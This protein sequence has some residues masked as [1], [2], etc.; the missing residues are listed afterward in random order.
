MYPS[1]WQINLK[2]F[3][4]FEVIL[5][6]FDEFMRFFFFGPAHRHLYSSNMNNE[7]EDLGNILQ[8]NYSVSSSSVP[9]VDFPFQFNF[10]SIYGSSL[11]IYFDNWKPSF[12]VPGVPTS[13]EKKNRHFDDFSSKIFFLPKLVGTPCALYIICNNCRPKP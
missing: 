5:H 13:F 9:S 7:A 12:F 11:T 8:Q 1:N 6:W 10:G 2:F 3:C 4:Q